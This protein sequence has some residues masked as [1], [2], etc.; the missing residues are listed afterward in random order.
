VFS[1]FVLHMIKENAI[2]SAISV[3]FFKLR[4]KSS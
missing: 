2:L 3:L 4:K 1:E